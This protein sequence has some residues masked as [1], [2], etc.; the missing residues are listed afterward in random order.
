[1]SET[2]TYRPG[3]TRGAEA[4]NGGRKARQGKKPGAPPQAMRRGARRGTGP[5]GNARVTSAV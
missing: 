2:F 1:M 5:A 4:E 3:G